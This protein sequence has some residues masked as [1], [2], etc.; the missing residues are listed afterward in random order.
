MDFRYVQLTLCSDYLLLI[1]AKIVNYLV[2]NELSTTDTVSNSSSYEEKE[3]CNL[4]TEWSEEKNNLQVI[5]YTSYYR[6]CSHG[7]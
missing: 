7:L 5:L 1:F 6:F 2:L 4:G 3:Y